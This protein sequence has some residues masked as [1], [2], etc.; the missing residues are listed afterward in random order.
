[1]AEMGNLARRALAKAMSGGAGEGAATE[2]TVEVDLES[3]G[4]AIMGKK[5]RQALESK[6]DA[7]LCRAVR[8]AY[9]GP[10]VEEDSEPMTGG[11]PDDDDDE[12]D[13]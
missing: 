13:A 3:S 9:A 10:G 6:D 12:V 2:T 4:D 8:E 1:M 11:Y 5:I 7:A